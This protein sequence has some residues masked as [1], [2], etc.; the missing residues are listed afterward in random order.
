MLAVAGGRRRSHQPGA[1][2]GAEARRSWAWPPLVSVCVCMCVR[3]LCA[4]GG[5]GLI[6]RK[7]KSTWARH[8]VKRQAMDSNLDR[9]KR[10]ESVPSPLPESL[11]F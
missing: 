9:V 5:D 2:M 4:A 8:R 3:V 10:V 6:L 1:G 7:R 11:I